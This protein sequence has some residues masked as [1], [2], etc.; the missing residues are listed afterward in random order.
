M[1]LNPKITQFLKEH[2]RLETPFLVI[3]LDAVEDQYRRLMRALPFATCY[4]SVKSNSHPEIIR[5][6][7]SLGARYEA[8]SIHEIEKCIRAG[9][10]VGDIHFGNPIKKAQ[11]ISRAHHLG[12]HSYTFDSEMELNKLAELAPGAKVSCRLVTDGKG[13]VWG[14][15]KKFGQPVEEVKRL[16]LKAEDLGLTPS[17]VAFHVGSQQHSPDAWCRALKETAEVFEFLEGHDIQ[18][19]VI[20]LG[21]GFPANGYNGAG[22]K[23]GG[24]DID[25]YGQ[26]IGNAIEEYFGKSPDNYH[27][28][29]EPGRFMVAEAGVIKSQVVLACERHYEESTTNWV[30][31]DVGKFSGMWEAGDLI[32]PLRVENKMGKNVPVI[33]AGP[34]CDSDDVLFH[35][36]LGVELP[37]DI[38]SGD[39][40]LF[41]NTGAYSNSYPTVAFNGFPPISEYYI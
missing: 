11:D 4:Y 16:L 21:G 38:T 8:A 12:I 31:L 13:A 35:R 1:D 27:V 25:E 32:Y 39:H 6:M 22:Y 14:L 20:N 2:P 15:C 26:T 3:D 41:L 19:E 7:K 30:Y 37:E 28:V 29:I 5:R 34:T 10:P 23:E 40:L 9:A 24:F 17:G 33:I 36:D 18:C